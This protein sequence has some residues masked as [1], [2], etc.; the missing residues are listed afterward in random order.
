MS[1]DSS[2]ISL[3]LYVKNDVCVCG[4]ARFSVGY[5]QMT[6]RFLNGDSFKDCW[7]NAILGWRRTIS[8][9]RHRKK[10]K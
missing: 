1:M 4:A 3:D 2:A 5:F 10:K 7:M 9:R 6:A 8:H